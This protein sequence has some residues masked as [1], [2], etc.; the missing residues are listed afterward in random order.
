MASF[1]RNI[2]ICLK[3]PRAWQL[4]PRSMTRAV[5]YGAPGQGTQCQTGRAS[6]LR[7]PTCWAGNQLLASSGSFLKCV[8]ENDTHLVELLPG[9]KEPVEV[10]HSAHGPAPVSS[11]RGA[12]L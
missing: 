5:E 12:A 7:P 1:T 11:Q 3:V 10:K 2:F 9:I 6:Q 4:L 8:S